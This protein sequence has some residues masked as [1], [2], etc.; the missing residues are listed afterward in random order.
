MGLSVQQRT[1]RPF[2]ALTLTV[3]GACSSDPVT[4]DADDTG[5]DSTTTGHTTQA[6]ATD[7]GDA[8]TGSTTQSGAS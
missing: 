5:G 1:S 2:L 6:L 4:N 8:Q 7:T 3:V